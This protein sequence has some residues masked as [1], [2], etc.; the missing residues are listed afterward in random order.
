MSDDT[1]EFIDLCRLM[2]DEL[3]DVCESQRSR[4][5][6]DMHWLVDMWLDSGDTSVGLIEY[7][8]PFSSNPQP[9][10]GTG[11]A[12]GGRALTQEERHRVADAMGD[13]LAYIREFTV[14]VI[15][16]AMRLDRTFD[17]HGV[18]TE[19]PAVEEAFYEREEDNAS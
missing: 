9:W 16:A 18:H 5:P 11:I 4:I 6:D 17:E 2:P 10:A 15:E 19:D 3:E 7:I 13:D 14:A 1:L 12:P 8:L